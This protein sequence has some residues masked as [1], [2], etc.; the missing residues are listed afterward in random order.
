MRPP[1]YSVITRAGLE[2][3]GHSTWLNYTCVIGQV[4]SKT[5]QLRDELEAAANRHHK[6][7]T[8]YQQTAD[9]VEKCWQK[10]SA[11]R[12]DSLL[13]ANQKSYMKVSMSRQLGMCVCDMSV[14]V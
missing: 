4:K 7:K 6:M 13:T 5:R 1:L 10:V 9:N 14:H 11:G 12:S 3:V 2:G 8:R